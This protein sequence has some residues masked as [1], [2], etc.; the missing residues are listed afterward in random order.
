MLQTE[1]S[2][3]IRRRVEDVYRFVATDFFENYPRW[4]AEV[5]E[6]EKL[7]CG[8]M[9]V[10]VVG[11]QVRSDGGYRSEARFQVTHYTPLLELRFASMTKPHFEV[12]YRFE[13]VACDT[14]L[15]FI[16]NLELP[17][18]IHPLR[19]RVAEFV[20]RGGSRVLVNLKIL[21]ETAPAL[22]GDELDGVPRQAGRTAHKTGSG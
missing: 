18:L 2:I 4:S 8:P 19:H 9:R 14:R 16:F 15:T 7:S 10:G 20:K 3:L 12:H 6:L 21:L 22:D 1:N 5:C 11:R 17:F 13:P